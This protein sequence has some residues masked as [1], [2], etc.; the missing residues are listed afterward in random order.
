MCIPLLLK[1]DSMKIISKLTLRLKL[2]SMVYV[3]SM[4]PSL[5]G[6]RTGVYKFFNNIRLQTLKNSFNLNIRDLRS[7]LTSVIYK[8]ASSW[9]ANTRTKTKGGN[10]RENII[11]FK[12]GHVWCVYFQDFVTI[13]IH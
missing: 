8:R 1:L 4:I 11:F 13:F 10:M 5:V 2:L 7:R 12:F 9:N 6:S 3:G